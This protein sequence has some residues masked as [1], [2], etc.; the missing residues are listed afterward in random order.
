MRL[1]CIAEFW[2]GPPWACVSASWRAGDAN[3]HFRELTD[4]QTELTSGEQVCCY[5]ALAGR[6]APCPNC[7]RQNM[8]EDAYL[9]YSLESVN[10]RCY[11]ADSRRI[12]WDGTPAYISY[13]SNI[14]KQVQEERR[15]H[16]RYAEEENKRH[17]LEKDVMA[18][19]VFNVTRGTLTSCDF[20]IVRPDDLKLQSG[21]PMSQALE[22]LLQE[23]AEEEDRT[24]LRQQYSRDR[25]L[26]RM[27]QGLV[28]GSLEYRRDNRRGERV[29]VSDEYNLV[30]EPVSKDV[31]CYTYVRSINE[32]KQYEQMLGTI[33]DLNYDFA[34]LI[35]RRTGR[36]TPMRQSGIIPEASLA[37]ARDPDQARADMLRRYCGDDDVEDLIRRTGMDAV[38]AALE[39]QPVYS[40]AF[41]FLER[42]KLR[43]KEM[44]FAYLDDSRQKIC[45]VRHDITDLS[46]AEQKKNRALSEA[47][48]QAREASLAKDDF[49][50]RMSHDIRT[51]LNG[52][53]GLTN[54]ALLEAKEGEAQTYLHQIQAS[55]QYLLSLVNDILDMTKISSH[56]MELHPAPYA[57]QEWVE[58][59]QAV[60]GEQS[61]QK[62][63]QFVLERMEGAVQTI[64]VDKLRFQQIFLNLLSN[65][66]KFTPSGGRVTLTCGA[67]PLDADH[68]RL[69]ITVTDTGCGMAPAFL[70]R[71]FDVF[72]QER[73]ASTDDTPGTGLG[74]SIVKSLVELMDGTVSLESTPGKGT[75]A[76]VELPV[77]TASAGPPSAVQDR[78]PDLSGCRI[79]LAEDHPVNAMIACKLLETCGIVVEH[80][81][82]GQ[83]AV[84]L[85]AA[86]APGSYDAVLMDIRMPLL[87]GLDATRAIRA[88]PRADAATVPILAM[89]A[90]AFE[91][92]VEKSLAAGMND[93]LAKPVVPGKLCEA[94]SRHIARNR[95]ATQKQS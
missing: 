22:Y 43:N 27:H 86:S 15:I 64:V 88:L 77:Q 42:G 73:T 1:K 44:T 12:D 83:R 75:R 3:R 19:C 92:D 70:E 85:F 6:D 90:N 67:V 66:V 5:Q 26:N 95:Q 17:L 56:K 34:M 80:A 62:G 50:S 40:V 13:I 47:L 91:D 52:I 14:T 72:A 74:L 65:A 82:N 8:T 45:C 4:L 31:I 55:G 57:Y 49:L 10:G 20:H 94:L 35:D 32:K 53:I 79:L 76:T 78:L 37:C 60:I 89:T 59:L 63:V 58:M 61:R 71:A 81:E 9:R 69:K 51:P 46:I 33:V 48:R 93:H 18:L 38:T 16:S 84:D 7:P 39:V 28:N 11:Q 2:K 30:E 36:A 87:D 24:K 41:T 21:M 23:V 68:C 25:L 29:W 54:L